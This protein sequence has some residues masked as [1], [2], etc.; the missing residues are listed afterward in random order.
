MTF[1]TYHLE[2]RGLNTYFFKRVFIIA[3]EDGRLGTL[4]TIPLEYLKRNMVKSVEESN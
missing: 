1:H 3:I 2:R 4:N